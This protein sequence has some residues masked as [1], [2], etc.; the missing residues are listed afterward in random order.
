MFGQETIHQPWGVVQKR[1]YLVPRT[2]IPSPSVNW[3]VEPHPRVI[4]TSLRPP[5]FDDS[6]SGPWVGGEQGP[7]RS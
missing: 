6:H 5:V 2:P 7:L 3:K 1:V 4:P